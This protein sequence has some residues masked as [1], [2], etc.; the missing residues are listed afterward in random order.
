MKRRCPKCAAEWEI[1]GPIGF[2]EECPQCAAF[3]H[4]CAH[5]RNYQ[6]G[7]KSCRLP[8]TEAVH[9]RESVNF[10]EEFEFGPPA[11]AAPGPPPAAKPPSGDARQRFE[12]LFRGPKT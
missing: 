9:D 11:V 4:T 10:C 2:R 6:P 3:M 7:T 1:K 12:D 8:D 5:C